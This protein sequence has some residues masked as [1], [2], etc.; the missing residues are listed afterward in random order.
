MIVERKHLNFLVYIVDGSH[1]HA[2]GDY[3]EGRV[4]DSL[5]FLDHRSWGVW[6]PYRRGVYDK[7]PD[8]GFVGNE[9]WFPFCR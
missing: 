4:L 3:A 8:K 5:E 6:K 9:G 1:L 7:V 2:A